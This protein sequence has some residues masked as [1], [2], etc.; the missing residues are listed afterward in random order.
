MNFSDSLYLLETL[1][2]NCDC[3]VENVINYAFMPSSTNIK[4]G[5]GAGMVSMALDG[6]LSHLGLP[7]RRDFLSNIAK[8]CMNCQQSSKSSWTDQI[9]WRMTPSLSADDVH[10]LSEPQRQA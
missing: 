5:R 8:A 10:W 4:Y 9:P 7:V 1:L 2:G 6:E 3:S